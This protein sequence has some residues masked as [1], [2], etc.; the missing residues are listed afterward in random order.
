MKHLALA[1]VL[2]LAVDPARADVPNTPSFGGPGTT[3]GM[4]REIDRLAALL[5][6]DVLRE[7]ICRL[8]YER[9]TQRSLSSALNLPADE[10]MRRVDVLRGWGLVRTITRDSVNSVVEP[11]TVE[12]RRTLRRWADKYCATGDSCGIQTPKEDIRKGSDSR[13]LAS[14]Q[15]S[16]VGV[17]SAPRRVKITLGRTNLKTVEIVVE[18]YDTPTADAIYAKL[19]QT[20]F[21]TTWNEGVYVLVPVRTSQ[22]PGAK[23]VVKP[24]EVGFWVQDGSIAIGYRPTPIDMGNDIRL[25]KKMVTAQV[26]QL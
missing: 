7:L 3:F 22:E 2:F 10:V 24:G 17:Q 23:D 18:L 21:V 15:S 6:D 12:G 16:G 8:S 9:Y 19:P 20:S 4:A 13:K 26:P 5:S 1:L 25:A 14:G 11:S